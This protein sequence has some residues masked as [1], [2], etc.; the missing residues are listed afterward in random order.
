[1][2]KGKAAREKRIAVSDWKLRVG[3]GTPVERHY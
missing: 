1:M 2:N 3:C